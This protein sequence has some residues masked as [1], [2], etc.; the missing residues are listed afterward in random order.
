MQ[1][2]SLIESQL[3]TVLALAEFDQGATYSDFDPDM[4]TVAAYGIGALVAGKALAKTGLIAA[5]IVF[6]K[7]FGVI[8]VIAIG[9]FLKKLWS[10]RK[11]TAAE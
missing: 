10:R 2:K 6:L 5:A 4:D 1:Q 7:K 8:F 11:N 3:D 9:A